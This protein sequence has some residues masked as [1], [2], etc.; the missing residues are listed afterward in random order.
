VCSV[1]QLAL[2][3]HASLNEVFGSS[4][5]CISQGPLAVVVSLGCALCGVRNRPPDETLQT[6]VHSL[7]AYREFPSGT[8]VTFCNSALP[9]SSDRQYK[10]LHIMFQFATV[11]HFVCGAYLT[12]RFKRGNSFRI[13]SNDAR[14][15]ALLRA[16]SFQRFSQS[17]RHRIETIRTLT[18]G[19]HIS[20]EKLI[21]KIFPR[22]F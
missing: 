21:N 20:I 17:V 13:W 4:N 15:S 14:A 3:A 11:R 1:R 18:P 8:L 12:S 2:Q 6:S 7:F 5:I 22:V 16:L 19:P 9:S 10:S